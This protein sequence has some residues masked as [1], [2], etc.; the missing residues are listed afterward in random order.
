MSNPEI[1][2]LGHFALITTDL[3][4][5]KW[6]F[7]EILGLEETETVDGVV[8]L[9][10]WGDFEHHTLSLQQGDESRIDHIAWRTKR[11]ED[12]DAFAKILEESGTEVTWVDAGVEAGQGRAIRFKLPS[13][14]SFE[15]YYDVEKPLAA[16][17]RRSVLKNQTY[18]SW[19]KGISPRRIDHVNLLTSMLANEVSDF[20]EEKLG[21]KMRECVQA[22]DNSLV[23]AW[24]SVT[25][26][27]HD[28]A[29]SHDPQSPTT[30]QI[31]HISYWLDNSQDLLR[32][33]DILTEHGIEFKGPGKHGISQAMYIY[34]IDPGSGV[35]VEIFTNG[36]LIFEPDWEP[37]V[38]TLDEMDIG[39]TYWGDQMDSK[40]ENNPTIKG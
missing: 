19:A 22:P 18:K 7:S 30:N 9:R 29:I 34:A 16:P 14:H 17:E 32:A 5:S 21:F 6:F 13:E 37:I 24:L 8:Y 12:V 11:P 23:G 27:V 35:R 20:L 1:A 26:L 39:F 40:T 2:K 10:A 38:W 36:Y 15:L 3:E 4:K 31:H 28:I 25:P 33:A